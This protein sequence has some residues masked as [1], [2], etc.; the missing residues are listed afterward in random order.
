MSRAENLGL[1]GSGLGN[2]LGGRSSILQGDG[3]YK[4]HERQG[5]EPGFGAKVGLHIQTPQNKK[6]KNLWPSAPWGS[7]PGELK[8]WGSIDEPRDHL[9]L[10]QGQ[11]HLAQ[12]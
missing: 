5:Q 12:Q 4:I 6:L 8:A 3:L 11:N 10:P 9:A 7:S 1:L 2:A